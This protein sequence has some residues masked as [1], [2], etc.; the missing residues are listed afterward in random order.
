MPASKQSKALADRANWQSGANQTGKV[1]ENEVHAKLDEL[2]EESLTDYEVVKQPKIFSQ[3]YLE[4]SHAKDPSVYKKPEEPVAKAIW[5]DESKQEFLTYT[6]TLKEKRA[7]CGPIPDLMIRNKKNGKMHFVEV[8]HQNDSGN[9]HERAAKY[10]SGLVAHMKQKIG[11]QNHPIS[12]I[13]GGSCVK[14]RKYILELEACYSEYSPGHLL[15]LD[16]ECNKEKI[17]QWFEM[18]VKPLLV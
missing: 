7:N 10:A 13:F 5:Y 8:K 6:N 17:M 12:Y 2:F 18:V 16:A 3:L 9:A 4:V 1:F 14:K 15:L 11:S